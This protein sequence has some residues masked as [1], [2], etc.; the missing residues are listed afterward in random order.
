M[1]ASIRRRRMVA[2]L[3]AAILTIAGAWRCAFCAHDDLG[4]LQ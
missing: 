2:A 1:V 3:L 4:V